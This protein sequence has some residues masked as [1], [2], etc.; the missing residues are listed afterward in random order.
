[1]CGESDFPATPVLADEPELSF[2][3]GRRDM[4][5]AENFRLQTVGSPGKRRADD[6]TE[7]QRKGLGMIRIPRNAHISAADEPERPLL[8]ESRQR[9]NQNH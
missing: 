2:S 7:T 6:G 4:E 5:R 1:M 9:S 3:I 8:G